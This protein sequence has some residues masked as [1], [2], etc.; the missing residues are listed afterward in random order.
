M[1]IECPKCGAQGLRAGTLFC[2]QCGNPVSG[3]PSKLASESEQPPTH[4]SDFAA[5]QARLDAL[6]SKTERAEREALLAR[7][8]QLE[9]LQGEI[10]ALEG[11]NKE[12]KAKT[13]AGTAENESLRTQVKELESLQAKIVALEAENRHLNDDSSARNL[14][15]EDLRKRLTKL[16]PL[17]EKVATLETENKKIKSAAG[18]AEYDLRAKVR[19]LEPLQSRVANLEAENNELKAKTGNQSVE[20]EAVRAQLKELQ[21]LQSRVSA[22]EAENRELKALK[23]KAD[24]EREDL[25]AKAKKLE[26]LQAKSVALEAENRELKAETAAESAEI[27]GLRSKAKELESLQT[28]FSG[29]EAE[30]RKLRD[31]G[32]AVSAEY[33]DLRARLRELE[34]LQGKVKEFDS[35]QGKVVT[36]EAE[37]K[38]I[39]TESATR[40]ADYERRM[41]RLRDLESKVSRLEA[42]NKELKTRTGTRSDGHE[43]LPLRTREVESLQTKVAALE[44]E[45]RELSAFRTESEIKREA[46]AKPEALAS[47]TISRRPTHETISHRRRYLGLFLV[48]FGVFT[49]L[50]SVIVGIVN[51]SG[52]GLASFLIGLLVVYLPSPSAVAPELME[53]SM[54]SSVS[55]LERVLRELGPETKAVYLAVHDRLDVPMIFLPLSDNPTH[56]LELA[57]L[58]QDRFLLVD[59]EDPHKS[60]LML[61]APG[62]SLL[63]LMER[64]SGVDFFDIE[65]D[66]LLDT[67]RSGMMESLEVAAD[68]K[69]TISEDPAKLRIKDGPL[70]GFARSVARSAPTVSS[71]LGCPICS[72]AVC[73]IAKSTKRDIVLEEAQHELGYH[74]VSLRFEE[75]APDET[76]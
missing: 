29:L 51:L 33:E 20:Y 49:V 16:G 58:D 64:E 19:E 35:L 43:D 1:S 48:A 68:L 38:K 5:L 50:A 47:R 44:V 62:A 9:P 12:L 15:Y 59:S 18:S 2:D 73:A 27:K 69:G 28:K 42:E 30:N 52:L 13:K 72:A 34:P 75:G 25:R 54:L 57:S 63:A 46:E 56:S 3:S 22:T 76:R 4:L 10:V 11:E 61:E 17:Q 60:G 71:R 31:K 32:A 67:L 66:D 65:R 36:L 39:E 37:K 14:E 21:P 6:E 8:K 55:N 53:A 26:P 41:L 40:T 70:S 74:S 24:A 23:E 45:N 7:V